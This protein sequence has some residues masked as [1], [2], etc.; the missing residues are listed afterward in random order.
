MSL[1]IDIASGALLAIGGILMLIG[2]IGMVRLPNFFTRL[3]AS[4]LTDTGGAA[5]LLLGLALQAGFTMVTVKLLLIAV[6]LFFTAPTSS[7]A[8]AHAALLGGLEPGKGDAPDEPPEPSSQQ[9][10]EA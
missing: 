6:F 4:G 8:V 3:H 5:T 1:V 9:A 10:D 7:H 2:G